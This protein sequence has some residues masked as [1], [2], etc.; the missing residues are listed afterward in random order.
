MPCSC[1]L[2]KLWTPEFS[3]DGVRKNFDM[4]RLMV[5]Y[6]KKM[7]YL[8]LF[9][10]DLDGCRRGGIQVPFDIPLFKRSKLLDPGSG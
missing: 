6:V 10:L 3:E 2:V 7:Y 4:S 9:S 8:A 1:T 5:N